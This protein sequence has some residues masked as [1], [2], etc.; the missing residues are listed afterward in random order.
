MLL[1]FSFVFVFSFGFSGFIYFSPFLLVFY[2][3][4]FINLCVCVC[5]VP[6]IEPQGPVS[7]GWVL[8]H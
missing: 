5:V 7:I 8:C 4:G 1:C 2:V 6:G 3:F